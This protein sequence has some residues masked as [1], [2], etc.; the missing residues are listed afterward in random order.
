[1]ELPQEIWLHW[2][3]QVLLLKNWLFPHCDTFWHLHVQEFESRIWFPT[4]D[5]DLLAH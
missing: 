2:H 4:Q 3:P 1:V 5:E